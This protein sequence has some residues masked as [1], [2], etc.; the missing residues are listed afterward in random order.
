MNAIDVIRAWKDVEYRLDLSAE[1]WAL[2]PKHPAG[3]VE[4][5]DG[6]IGYICDNPVPSA[7]CITFDV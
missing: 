1:Q 6:D 5:D 7:A 2:L 3:E 4:L